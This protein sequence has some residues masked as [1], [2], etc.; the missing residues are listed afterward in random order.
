MF[1]PKESSLFIYCSKTKYLR[2][3][4]FTKYEELESRDYKSFLN[5]YNDIH[6]IKDLSDK[7][8]QT[9]SC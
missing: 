3:R 6:I 5:C 4:A 7:A 8:S 9:C 2:Y 1:Y